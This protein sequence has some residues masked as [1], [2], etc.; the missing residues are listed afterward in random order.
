MA[1]SQQQQQQKQELFHT[2]PRTITDWC[3][4]EQQTLSL[5]PGLN[6]WGHFLCMGGV[7]PLP[8]QA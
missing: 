7:I 4:A 1:L 2:G 3:P 5:K 6:A 8:V